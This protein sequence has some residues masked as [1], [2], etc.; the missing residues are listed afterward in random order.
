MYKKATIVPLLPQMYGCNVL[1]NPGKRGYICGVLFRATVWRDTVMM[2]CLD[3]HFPNR[4]AVMTCATAYYSE[5][6]YRG[7]KATFQSS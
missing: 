2:K 5:P 6:Y 1:N 7:L 3:E 4:R